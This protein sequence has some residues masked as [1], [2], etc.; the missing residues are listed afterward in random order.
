M[1]VLDSVG[2]PAAAACAG[3]LVG[4]VVSVLDVDGLSGLGESA[5]DV[6]A[7][8][9]AEVSSGAA[10]SVEL[11]SARSDVLPAPTPTTGTFPLPLPSVVE[12]GEAASDDAGEAWVAAVVL[13]LSR[14]KETGSDNAINRF[15]AVLPLPAASA[16]LSSDQQDDKTGLDTANTF[17]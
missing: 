1:S 5:L 3:E 9:V 2:W 7:L 4:L 8:A 16:F 13:A 6:D 10:G 17:V 11:S 12:A 14:W 15:A